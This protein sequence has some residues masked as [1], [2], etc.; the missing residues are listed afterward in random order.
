MTLAE[1]VA[2]LS[3]V[4]VADLITAGELDL[5]K[6]GVWLNLGTAAITG[7]SAIPDIDP[8]S[9]SA[10]CERLQDYLRKQTRLGIPALICEGPHSQQGLF[11]GDLIPPAIAMAASFGYG[12]AD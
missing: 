7:I 4:S 12:A 6:L 8:A 2:Q 11:N 5:D 9:Y 10:L 1:K 3:A